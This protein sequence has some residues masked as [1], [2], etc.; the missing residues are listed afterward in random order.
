MRSF[1]DMTVKMT[2]EKISRKEKAKV[3]FRLAL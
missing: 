1:M 3:R 2:K